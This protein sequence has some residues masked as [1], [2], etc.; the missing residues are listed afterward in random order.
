[1]K[2][3]LTA[4][5]VAL[6]AIAVAMVVAM[7]A[8]AAGNA[9][10]TQV[11]TFDPTGAVFSCSN[12]T[13]YTVTG[14]L[15]RAV[16]HDSVDAAGA[17]HITGTTALNGVT[18]TDGVTSTVYRIAGASWF[19][20]SFNETTGKFVTTDTAHFNILGPSGGPVA[21]VSA[22]EHFS[23]GGANFSMSFGQCQEPQN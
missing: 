3:R 21:R 13:S 10:S 18:L 4:V 20:G 9:G 19:G 17:E 15:A 12:G 7:P 11:T 8:G 5:L 23:S 1:M 22:V 14:G 6:A 2:H 16:F